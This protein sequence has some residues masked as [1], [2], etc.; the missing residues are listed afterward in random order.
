ADADGLLAVGCR[1]TQLVTGSWKLRVPEPL[2][3]LDIDP[4]EI[5]RHY[6]P[7]VRLVGD[8][9]ATLR[10]MIPPFPQPRPAWGAWPPAEPWT[11]GGMNLV[12]TLPPVL[13]E[14]AI[15]AAD[16]TRAAYIL[17]SQLPL[18]GRRS[19]LHPAGSVAMG[20]ALPAALGAK[21][22]FPERP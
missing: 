5:G 10:A 19:W 22:A 14:D 4:A 1:F 15:V 6:R 20:Y 2:V 3:H 7:A 18:A 13:P 17:M 16:V 12:E 11:L 9:R 8:A 21:A